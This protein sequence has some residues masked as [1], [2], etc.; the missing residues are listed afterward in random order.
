MRKI[1]LLILGVC[2]LTSISNP[3]FS[4]K[5]LRLFFEKNISS[6][7]H[8]NLEEHEVQ[9]GEW[10]YKILI[11]KGYS[12]AEIDSLLPH[13]LEHN[14]HI[15]DINYLKAGQK[16]ILPPD[17]PGKKHVTTS[18]TPASET[19]T[20]KAEHISYTVQSGDSLGSILLRHNMPASIAFGRG[21]DLFQQL[22][23]DITNVNELKAGQ[24]VLLPVIVP[25]TLPSAQTATA[26]ETYSHNASFTGALD[27]PTQPTGQ[28]HLER[29]SISQRIES[30]N[31]TAWS[32][33][34]L[35]G[36][37]NTA[38]NESEELRKTIVQDGRENMRIPEL[39]QSLSNVD[40]IRSMLES[41]QANQKTTE[42]RTPRSGLPFVRSVLEQMQFVFM[43]GD[44]VIYP[45]PKSE[46]LHIKLQE[47]P[48][49]EAPWGSKILLCATPKNSQWIDKAHTLNIQVCSI[50]GTWSLQ[51]IFAELR[52]RFPKN[53]RLWSQEKELVWTRNGMNFSLKSPHLAII[54]QAQNKHIYVVW[55]RGAQEEPPLPQGLPEVL[56]ASAIKVIE[57][58]VFNHLSRLPA[59]PS[60]SIIVSMA[61]VA[62]LARVFDTHD[63]DDLFGSSMP[64]TL[65]SFLEVLKQKNRLR[66]GMIR[67][68]WVRGSQRLMAIQV[69]AWTIVSGQNTIALLDQCFADEH[70]LSLFAHQGYTCFILPD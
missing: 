26:I 37:G 17:I 45:L 51:N 23:P 46:W 7:T 10:L 57:L 50:G 69:P 63:R 49:V 58:D 53:F 28:D 41:D 27:S 48:L 24:E 35:T 9:A 70:L 55:A 12:P 60:G 22:N 62:E 66:Q 15:S 20:P 47:T 40:I 19:L 3:G 25:P 29:D 59:R 36:V 8:V 1:A 42:P 4:E 43:P 68:A 11:N 67:A 31:A 34:P 38:G 21:F 65:H 54:E 14:T 52:T 6:S 61:S 2:L 32:L 64:D 33:T 39:G 56:E 13:I 5:P 30:S 18:I 44:E 16:L